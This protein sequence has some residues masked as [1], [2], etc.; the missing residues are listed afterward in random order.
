MIDLLWKKVGMTTS[1]LRKRKLVAVA[2]VAIAAALGVSACSSSGAGAS[3]ANTVN[4]VAFSTPKPA[5]DALTA[6]FE[7]TSAGKGV[8][9]NASYGPS[10]TQ[11]KNVLGGQVDADFVNFSTASDLT[12]LVPSK[13][14]AGW[15][16]GATKGDVADSVVVLVVR[17]GNPKNITGWDDLI[18]PGVK[19]VTT[20]PASSGSAKWNILAAY[21]HI[22]DQGGSESDAADYLK[23]FFKNVVSRAASG[24]D[25]AQQFLNGTG[26]VLLSYESEAITARASGEDVD[27]VV[28]DQTVLIQTVAAVTTNASKAAKD[29]LDYAES[30][31]G[32]QIVASK[33]WRPALTGVDPGTVHGALD[34]SNP[35]PQ[36]QTLTTIDDLG[37]WDAVNDKFFSENGIV[38]K[39]EA[40]G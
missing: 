23:S 28:P 4:L 37:G 33:G 39:I 15:D 21:Q 40:S 25:A 16:G 5:Y 32:Q 20:D 35:Y 14:A 6:A 3:D 7:K 30:S 11:S 22:I 18:K 27:Y 34:P 12:K 1:L 19:I 2:A 38:T 29:F 13:V 17:K 31:A 9:F 8:E 10:G 24:S 26:D 36:P